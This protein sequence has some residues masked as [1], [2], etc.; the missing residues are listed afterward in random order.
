MGRKTPVHAA[1]RTLATLPISVYP[2]A[3][4]EQALTFWCN[5][6]L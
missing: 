6:Y 3:E 5:M 1:S 4:K 2:L